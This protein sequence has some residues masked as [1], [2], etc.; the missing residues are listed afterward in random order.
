MKTQR[1]EGASHVNIC[2]CT[3]HV[4]GTAS[5]EAVRQEPTWCVLVTVRR[6][7]WLEWGE[8]KR[9]SNKTRSKH[10]GQGAFSF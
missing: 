7:A 1:S 8:R 10:G 3:F 6:P 5:A 2:E 9:E 4:N